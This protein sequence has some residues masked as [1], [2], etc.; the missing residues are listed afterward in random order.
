[1]RSNPLHI[2]TIH[3][4]DSKLP[5]KSKDGL[6]SYDEKQDRRRSKK[7]KFQKKSGVDCSKKKS[8]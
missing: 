8:G 7:E 5:Y 1:M 3:D 2:P 6:S 4:D